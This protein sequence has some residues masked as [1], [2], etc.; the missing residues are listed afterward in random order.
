MTYLKDLAKQVPVAVTW[1]ASINTCI[2]GNGPDDCTVTG[3]LY[4]AA[5]REPA[6]NEG[7]KVLNDYIQNFGNDVL[8][9]LKQ[10]PL[11]GW[12]FRTGKIQTLESRYSDDEDRKLVR[13]RQ[14]E[15]IVSGNDFLGM[16]KSGMLNKGLVVK[17][18]GK[19]GVV[20]VLLGLG[21]LGTAGAGAL[22]WWHWNDLQKMAG[23]IIQ[24]FA[25][26][27][28]GQVDEMKVESAKFY[29]TGPEKGSP[30]V[31]PI[32]SSPSFPS[33]GA[34]DRVVKPLVVKKLSPM[35]QEPIQDDWIIGNEPSDSGN[36]AVSMNDLLSI[37]DFIKSEILPEVE[38]PRIST[39]APLRV[40]K[41][42]PLR[43]ESVEPEAVSE[44]ALGRVTE[45]TP[46]Y[47]LPIVPHDDIPELIPEGPGLV[48]YDRPPFPEEASVSEISDI[49][50]F[51]LER[52]PPTIPSWKPRPA[53][54]T[55]DKARLP[56]V[57]EVIEQWESP[58]SEVEKP[59]TEQPP[60]KNEGAVAASVAKVESQAGSPVLSRVLGVEGEDIPD[61]HRTSYTSEFQL[62][63]GLAP[64][65]SKYIRPLTE[66]Y[67]DLEKNGI[68]R[69]DW[70]KA[71]N[72]KAKARPASEP[73][74]IGTK[75]HG[76]VLSVGEKQLLQDMFVE[77]IHQEAAKS[78]LGSHSQ[79]SNHVD[80]KSEEEKGSVQ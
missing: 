49:E 22:A 15:E 9:E 76:K 80:L 58:P 73:Q 24:S 59:S 7:E 56:K 46:E 51:E 23:E 60:L 40:T 3:Q 70:V 57:P 68:A 12:F 61:S 75:R 47:H 1:D 11:T 64:K 34:P 39:T 41:V 6:R 16:Y 28:I 13:R 38:P 48:F 5:D 52:S 30:N 72:T 29:T 43:E 50:E 79:Q 62:S 20:P 35:P 42:A 26:K 2:N 66:I 21:A 33:D 18:K 45:I 32:V 55:V 4:H 74:D 27:S 17:K 53:W 44:H 31:A 10:I 25:P 65:D 14:A 71:L 54:G 36:A 77:G 78:S 69:V 67:A 37:S 63:K 8:A 19:S